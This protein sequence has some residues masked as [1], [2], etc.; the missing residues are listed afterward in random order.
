LNARF[1]RAQ[2]L[3]GVAAVAATFPSRAG[4]QGTRLRICGFPVDSYAAPYYAL[5]QGFL[6]RNGI[7]LEIVTLANA[8]GVAQAIIA[9]AIDIGM[10]DA[11]QVANPFM[12][13]VPMALFGGSGLY[14]SD[15]PA[16]VL[17]VDKNSP[18]QKPKDL[19]GQAIG[20]VALGSLTVLGVREWL[21]QSGVDLANVKVVEI[22][23]AAMPAALARGTLGAA[24]LIEPFLSMSRDVVRP[25]G[26][27]LD[28]IASSFY[29]SSFFASTS[30]LGAN[31]DLAKRFLKAMYDAQRWANTHHDES[32]S[33]LT[34]YAKLD[35]SRVS[36]MTRAR[37][38][39][40]LDAMRI[41]PVLD[42]AYKW[43]QLARP[44]N[45]KDIT[46]TL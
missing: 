17:M 32:A 14:S 37:Y 20:V 40:S 24:V 38:A 44:L 29:L 21:G 35:P 16:S 39:T 10:G 41:Q 1:S 30:W 13:N 43:K 45:A 23:T 5:D 27:P 36:A 7:D 22:P 3:A 8:G 42:V 28:A 15:A 19:E 9:Q 34:K 6:A 33:I 18:F 25:I 26:K 11:L 31:R 4:A 46:F 2:A 12:A